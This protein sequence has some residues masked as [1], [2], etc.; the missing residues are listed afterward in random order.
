MNIKFATICVFVFLYHE[1]IQLVEDRD[2][3]EENEIEYD[4]K[5]KLLNDYKKGKRPTGTVQ[6]RLAIN[7][8]QILEIFEKDQIMVINCFIDQ[9][10]FDP[11]LKWSKN[12]SQTFSYY[13]INVNVNFKL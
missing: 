11:R 8:F 4:L 1:S 5:N 10:W 3:R 2:I 12:Y 7:S 13:I 6:I 9:K